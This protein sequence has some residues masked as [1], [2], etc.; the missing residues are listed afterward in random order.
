MKMKRGTII[1]IVVI[2]VVLLL[3]VICIASYNGLVTKSEAVDDKLA[4]IDTQ[5]ERRMSLI[6]NLVNT[7]KGYAQH[8]ETV[9][10]A[11]LEARTKLAGASTVADKDAANNELSSALSRL[12][13]V[14][15]NYP[16]LKANENFLNLQDELAGTE[17]RIA[18]AR[19]EYNEAVKRYNTDIKKF[20]GNIFAGLFGF[21]ARDYFNA[22]AE[23]NEVPQVSFS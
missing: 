17:N 10:N 5:L 18:N 6:P 7:V 14:V 15:E 9:M 16:D 8:E 23:A 4:A 1:L 12:L 11:V 13:V 21:T 3:A 2:A 20:P 22:S 19:R